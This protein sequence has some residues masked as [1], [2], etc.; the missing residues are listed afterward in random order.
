VRIYEQGVFWIEGKPPAKLAILLR[1]NAED[2]L[3]VD[4]RRY[5]EN[6][7]DTVVSLLEPREAEW[8]GLGLEARLARELGMEFL[9]YP[10]RDT[11]IPE[12]TASFR[13]FVSGLAE[14]LRAGQG[15]GVHCRGSIG[16]STVTAACTLIHLGWS[17]AAALE[18][19]RI[20]RGCEVP[21]TEEQLRWIL[22]YEAQP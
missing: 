14:R 2:L 6:G 11:H 13:E 12:H 8:L 17:P 16:R 22:H 19:I 15:I 21:D 20:A 10:I 1:P 9:N 3:E 4:L 7:V 5:R 18:A